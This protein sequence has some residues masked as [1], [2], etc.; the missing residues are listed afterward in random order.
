[1]KVTVITPAHNEEKVIARCLASVKNLEVPQRVD[2]EHLVVLDR[3]TDSTKEICESYGVKIL[4]KNWRGKFRHS[5]GEAIDFAI[6]NSDGDL[7]MKVDSDIQVTNDTLIKLLS[8]LRGNVV[9]VSAKVKSRTGKKRL[10][11][12]MWLRDVSYAIA[13]LGRKI[14]GACVLFRRDILEK[15]GGFDTA[16]P[17]W[18]S[19]FELKLFSHGYKTKVAD[20]LTV[21]EC[22]ETTA[23]SMIRRQIS[24]GRARKKMGVSFFRTL[25]HALFRGRPFVLWGY[26]TSKRGDD[27]SL[28]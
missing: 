25:L 15:V 28:R 6:K 19:G 18:D 9:C 22:R 26:L 10:D 16:S 23:I 4:E 14:Y 12:F 20:D 17:R 1:V 3:C 5:V 24:D 13:P 27:D 21:V 11:F 7:I 2:L 8:H